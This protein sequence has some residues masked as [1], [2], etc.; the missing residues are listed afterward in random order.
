ML[1]KKHLRKK[2]INRKSCRAGHER[3]NE[4]GAAAVPLGCQRTGCHDRRNRTAKAQKHR[5]K[6]LS[7]EPNTAHDLI[8]NIGNSGHVSAVFQERQSQKQDK[9]VR[10]EG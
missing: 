5:Q 8:H 2:Y 7:G 10:Q 1:F 6:S 9:D 4:N 3:C